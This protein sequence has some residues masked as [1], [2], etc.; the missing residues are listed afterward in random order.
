MYT[1][2]YMYV[3][4]DISMHTNHT[5]THTLSRSN[6]Y[7]RYKIKQLIQFLINSLC[8][9]SFKFQ[10][11]LYCAFANQLK[12]QIP[13]EPRN[14]EF[15]RNWKNRKRTFF[16]SQSNNGCTIKSSDKTRGPS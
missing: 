11:N 12:F 14:G 5:H 8:L 1:A 16:I 15:L 9:F 2:I 4:V 6:E 7:E 3:C 13:F 10:I